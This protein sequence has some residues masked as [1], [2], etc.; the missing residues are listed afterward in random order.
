MERMER[1][2]FG[3]M[4]K[5]VVQVLYEVGFL[6][7][8]EHKVHPCNLA[9]LL[10]LQLCITARHDDKGPGVFARHLMNGLAAFVVG[11]FGHTAR[12]N[13]ADVGPLSLFGRNH[14]HVGQHFAEGRRLREV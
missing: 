7:G 14:P 4:D 13:Q 11:N 3:P 9:H 6:I 8:A 12:V 10:R 2:S 1:R 5:S